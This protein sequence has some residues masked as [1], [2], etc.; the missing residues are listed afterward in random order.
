MLNNNILIVTQNMYIGGVQKYTYQLNQALI[1]LNY[2]VDI[3]CYESEKT[4]Q[5]YKKLNYI[6][7]INKK[8][9]YIFLN[10]YPLSE[11]EILNY[12]KYTENIISIC[13]N[14]YHLFTYITNKILNYFY[15]VISVSDLIINKIKYDNPNNKFRYSVI[16]PCI[17]NRLVETTS[18]KNNKLFYNLLWC[19]RISTLKG[20]QLLV[21]LYSDYLKKRP[22]CKKWKL[23]IYGEPA[24]PFLKNMIEKYKNN[25]IILNLKS[26]DKQDFELFSNNI[27]LFINTSYTDGIPYTFLEFL[28]K[29][30]P[31]ISS[32]IGGIN[33]LIY[34]EKN[35][36][37]FN[38][39]GLYVKDFTGDNFN[40][41]ILIENFD[42]EYNYN[43]KIFETIMDKYLLN[44]KKILQIKNN[45]QFNLDNFTIE[46][47][48]QTSLNSLLNS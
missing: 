28:S 27:D 37:L 24:K 2:N 14:E 29:G 38:F 41:N 39:K 5:H 11:E 25:N 30:I 8:Y 1:N 17:T 45:C 16:T 46:N 12:L 18:R 26:Y 13:H 15:A 40:Y 22:Q 23:F 4:L 9:R 43:Y 42:N 3:K 34:P 7:D 10:S 47:M 33:S 36:D 31:I 48:M 35:G 19:G 32:N 6:T 20:C 21:K 44:E